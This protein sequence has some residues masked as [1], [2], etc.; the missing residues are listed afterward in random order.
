LWL[1]HPCTLVAY[2]L[3]LLPDQEL[4]KGPSAQKSAMFLVGFY[5]FRMNKWMERWTDVM[6][7][8]RRALT[9]RRVKVSALLS[10]H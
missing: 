8:N 1:L 10:S 7:V 9:L 4:L 3:L 6:L 2:G 5:W